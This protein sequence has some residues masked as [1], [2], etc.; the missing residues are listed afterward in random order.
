MG[1][2]KSLKEEILNLITEAESICKNILNNVQTISSVNKSPLLATNPKV[3]RQYHSW[4][5]KAKKI[6][7]KF[8]PDEAYKFE[9]EFDM[10]IREYLKGNDVLHSYYN[11][12]EKDRFDK[13]HTAINT[14]IAILNAIYE[15]FD[16]IF[17]R[18]EAYLNADAFGDEL[19]AS[20][21][22]HKNKFYRASGALAGVVLERHL[23]NYCMS[24][25][26]NISKKNPSISVYNEAIKSTIDT[27]DWR[28]IQLLGDLRNLCDHDKSEEPT[29][30]KV[31]ELIDGVE[32]IIK[33]I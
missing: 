2:E 28:K 32:Y 6:C 25:N 30:E 9:M 20:K 1:V 23:R 4:F 10:I 13:F 22:L 17:R 33:T 5:F 14:Q 26:I 3:E 18:F 24:N 15:N 19:D 12:K 16:T 29:K 8:Y 31:K 7:Q 21:H 11:K 27:S